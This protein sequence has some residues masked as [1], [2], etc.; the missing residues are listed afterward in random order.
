MTGDSHNVTLD[1]KTVTIVGGSNS[2]ECER[3]IDTYLPKI[4]DFL[5]SPKP[6]TIGSVYG[7]PVHRENFLALGSI[8]LTANELGLL[9]ENDLL[10]P[11]D[12]HTMAANYCKQVGINRQRA[13]HIIVLSSIG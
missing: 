4:P 9:S 11:V 8:Y 13:S 1:G 10:R 7:P 2:T 6:C 12:M 5:C 3:I